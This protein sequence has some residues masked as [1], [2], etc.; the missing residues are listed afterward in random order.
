[1]NYGVATFF[2]SGVE[3][4]KLIEITNTISIYLTLKWATSKM[5]KYINL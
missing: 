4:V 2:H 3:N 5:S 1:M